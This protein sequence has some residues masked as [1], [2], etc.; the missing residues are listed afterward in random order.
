[1]AINPGA[2]AATRLQPDVP[3]FVP[4]QLHADVP[5]FVPGK[6]YS[7]TGQSG[8]TLLRKRSYKLF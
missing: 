6:M 1:M 5:E 2:L 3:E 7:F 8:E 4:G